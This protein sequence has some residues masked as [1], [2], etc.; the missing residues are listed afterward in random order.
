LVDLAVRARPSNESLSLLPARYH[1]FARA[2]EGVFA[3]LNAAAHKDQQPH[4]F[5]SRHTLCPE[6]RSWV[7]E[8]ANCIRCGATYIV[9]RG[10]RNGQPGNTSQERG[11]ILKQ[12][13]DDEREPERSSQYFLVESHTIGVDEDQAVTTHE[14]L[15]VHDEQ[16]DQWYLCLKCGMCSISEQCTCG[17]HAPCVMLH[18]IDLKDKPLPRHC[19]SCGGRSTNAII[20]RFL[21]GQDAPVSV[22]TAALYQQL[23]ASTDPE[24]AELLPGGGRKLLVFSDSRQDASF[25]APYLERTYNQILHRRLILKALHEDADGRLGELRIDDVVRRLLQQTENAHIF[26]QKD[27]RDARKH[28]VSTWL[29]QELIALG[30]RLSLEGLGLLQFR[31]V[32]PRGWQPPALLQQAPWKLQLDEIWTLITLLLDTL[33]QQGVTTFPDL[34]DPKDEAFQP[35]NYRFFV[36]K[37][38]SDSTAGILSWIPTR[39]SNRR[40]NLLKRLLQRCT[41][42]LTAKEQSDFAQEALEGLWKH[43]TEGQTWKMHLASENLAKHGIVYRLSYDFWEMV[44]LLT[45]QIYRCNHCH[46]LTPI[47]LRN[48]CPTLNCSGQL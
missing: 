37:N 32:R 28:A 8:L 39:G 31:L 40:M 36:R 48:C 17:S 13:S 47:S 26:T 24:L 12:V 38:Q 44:P 25:F 34:V 9:G 46:M 41:P 14:Q 43:L 29:M 19:L 20:F 18:E 33:R 22:L 35:R 3:C 4:I 5:L 30:H 10:V 21:T 45:G 6:C 42:E 27:S 15:D 16:V 7:V 23:P 2:L 1:G 11:G